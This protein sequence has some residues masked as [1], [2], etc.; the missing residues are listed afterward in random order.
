MII[1][2]VIIIIRWIISIM[3]MIMDNIVKIS[4]ID[5]YIYISISMYY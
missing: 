5:I 3:S 2:I 1:S 4:I